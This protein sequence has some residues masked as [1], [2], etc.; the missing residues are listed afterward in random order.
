MRFL[1]YQ[2]V[3]QA[4]RDRAAELFGTEEEPTSLASRIM[5]VKSKLFDAGGAANG[6]IAAAGSSVGGPLASRLSRIKL[7]DKEKTR[8]QELI[9]KAD[10]LQDI[11]RLERELNEGRLPSGVHVPDEM[12]E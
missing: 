11:I 5:G 7:T 12:E 3:K 4:E 2:K 9:R 1:D 8:L 6:S 10:S